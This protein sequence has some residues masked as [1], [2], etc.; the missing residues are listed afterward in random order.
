MSDWPW[1]TVLGEDGVSNVSTVFGR[2]RVIKEK[3]GKGLRGGGEEE[4]TRTEESK[5]AIKA[6][7]IKVRKNSLVTLTDLLQSTQDNE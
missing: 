5:S 1:M 4:L 3:G 7:L 6:I 2:R